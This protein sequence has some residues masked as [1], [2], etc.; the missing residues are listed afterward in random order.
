[1]GKASNKHMVTKL[2]GKAKPPPGRPGGGLTKSG[3]NLLSRCSH[4]HRPGLLNGRVRNGNG[5][6]QPGMV[7]GKTHKDCRL[8]ILDCRFSSAFGVINLRSGYINW[9]R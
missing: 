4:Y 1:M 5:C 3:D 9:Q 2:T 8:M 6:G 7:T